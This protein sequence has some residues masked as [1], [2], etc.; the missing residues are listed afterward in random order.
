MDRNTKRPTYKFAMAK[1]AGIA[2]AI[3]F[4]PSSQP[5]N[6]HDEAMREIKR[7]AHEALGDPSYADMYNILGR[8]WQKFGW[9][10]V[11]RADAPIPP[12]DKEQR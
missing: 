6:I 4:D 2:S 8:G 3:D 1:I 7:I 11:A 5:A 12:Y 10:E 9:R